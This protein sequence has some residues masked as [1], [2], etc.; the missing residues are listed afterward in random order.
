MSPLEVHD[1]G[2]HDLIASDAAIERIAGGL[3]FTE[4]PVWH[5]EATSCSRTSRPTASS[6]GTRTA[7]PPPS[8]RQAA[9]RTA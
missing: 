4:G 9:T 1:P 5:R 2:L 8:A 7:P 6:A 3:G